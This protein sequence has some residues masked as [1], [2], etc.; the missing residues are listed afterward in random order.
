MTLPELGVE[1]RVGDT[2]L[3]GSLRKMGVGTL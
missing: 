3:Q 1:V 2:E